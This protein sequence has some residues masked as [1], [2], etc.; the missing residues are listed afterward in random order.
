MDTS[1][2][3]LE[4]EYAEVI[5]KTDL[6]EALSDLDE[7]G[8]SYGHHP[9]DR[10]VDPEV[11][12]ANHK[13][14]LPLSEED[15]RL[16]IRVGHQ[17]SFGK[18]NTTIIDRSVPKTW[19]L[20]PESF[21]IRSPMWA[22]TMCETVSAVAKDMTLNS[23]KPGFHAQLHKMLVYEKGAMFKPHQDAEKV[24]GM[25][26][27]LVVALPSP[28]TGG[29]VRTQLYDHPERYFDTRKGAHSF[30]W[31]YPDTHD[32]VLPFESGIR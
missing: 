16:L 28:H 9:M 26:A 2:E 22:N 11:Y 15:T 30:L 23:D 4:D 17:A 10:I 14:Q 5:M 24:P 29:L 8:P 7:P 25:F 21:E 18:K 32:E 3:E 20:D 6:I 19:E 31:W 13:V 27:T 12:V 1:D